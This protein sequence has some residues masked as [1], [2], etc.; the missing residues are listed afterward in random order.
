VAGLESNLRALRKTREDYIYDT[1]TIQFEKPVD[2]KKHFM[3]KV[4]MCEDDSVGLLAVFDL[5]SESTYDK[6]ESDDE[7]V[8]TGNKKKRPHWAV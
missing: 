5:P 3:H 2:S 7:I 6:V 8:M 1:C 4:F